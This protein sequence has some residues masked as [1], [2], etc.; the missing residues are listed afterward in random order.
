MNGDLD[1][2]EMSEL[3]DETPLCRIGDPL[4]VAY[5]AEFLSS[6]RASFIT[7]QTIGID[8]GFAL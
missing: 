5:L 2:S 6:E 8:G 1:E 3:V 4:E 7:G